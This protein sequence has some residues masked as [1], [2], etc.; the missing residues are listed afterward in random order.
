MDAS[1]L[2]AFLKQ[3]PGY[4]VVASLL[5]D[6]RGQC[7]AH[8]VNLLEV[9]IWELRNSG[10]EARADMA[11]ADLQ[12]AG[13]IVREDIEDGFCRSVSQLKKRF[14]QASLGDCFC[15]ALAQRLGGA[16]ITSDHPSFDPAAKAGVVGV[17]FI[18]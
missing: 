11:F 13:V 9:R 5:A 14:P 4:S 2:L 3:E 12:Q 18:R 17:V 10:D 1:A 8:A 15:M 7:Y 16:V 6:N